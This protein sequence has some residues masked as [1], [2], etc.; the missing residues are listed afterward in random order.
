MTIPIGVLHFQCK[1]PCPQHTLLH[2]LE[3][4]MHGVIGHRLNIGTPSLTRVSNWILL[5]TTLAQ[6]GQNVHLRLASCL[7]IY[8]DSLLLESCLWF[9][10]LSLFFVIKLDVDHLGH[11]SSAALWVIVY[12]NLGELELLFEWGWSYFSHLQSSPASTKLVVRR[13]K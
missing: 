11:T 3:G 8:L 4:F 1:T 13:Y 2:S 10:V 12:G 7:K 9:V 5:V 6:T